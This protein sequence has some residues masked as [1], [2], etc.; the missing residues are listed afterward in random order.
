MEIRSMPNVV[1]K[2]WWKASWL[3]AAAGAVIAVAP[4]KACPPEEQSQGENVLRAQ[5]VQFV[6]MSMKEQS[7]VT[8]IMSQRA[9]G[10]DVTVKIQDDKTTA[11]I[12]GKAVPEDRI[13]R[14]DRK[15]EV[16]DEDGDVVATFDVNVGIAGSS[17]S[18]LGTRGARA[19][20]VQGLMNAQ[21]LAQTLPRQDQVVVGE[22]GATAFAM[23]GKPRVMLGITMSPNED[24][25]GVVIDRV[26]EGLPADKAGLKAGDILLGIDTCV[27]GK[28]GDVRTVL[29]ERNPG[30]VA[31]LKIERDGKPQELKLTLEA[32]EPH[33]LATASAWT[34]FPST[35]EEHDE[36]YFDEA[37][38][39]IDRAIQEL[40]AAQRVGSEELRERMIAGLEKSRQALEEAQ[41][42]TT[43]R[44][45]D[46]EI[47]SRDAV[48]GWLNNDRSVFG[49]GGQV[50]S[51]APSAPGTP[52][53]MNMDDLTKRLDEMS[54]RIE[55]M[56]RQL[57]E[58]E[59]RDNSV[60]KAT[61][62]SAQRIQE[63]ADRIK[64]LEEQ[65][66]KEKSKNR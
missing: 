3:L 26:V 56:N 8:M 63:M 34:R 23:A 13:H 61:D 48:R 24:G 37:R 35:S 25:S 62:S 49:P 17:N 51:T 12:D 60:A 38:A 7:S 14:S 18:L 6:P 41:V 30:E 40:K 66:A 46:A 16:L 4:A 2:N 1:L 28:Q 53:A 55:E 31:T 45:R 11:E 5:R 19:P 42:R 15:I 54:R 50:Y 20:R 64:Q 65:L 44:L 9:D 39:R 43:E 57:H 33:K 58:R 29:N 36:K 32:I 52:G 59:N 27:I 22:P 10:H 47:A 21:P